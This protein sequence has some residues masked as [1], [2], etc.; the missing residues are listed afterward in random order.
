[1]S[2]GP[3]PSNRAWPGDP[4]TQCLTQRTQQGVGV[5]RVSRAGHCQVRVAPDPLPLGTRGG[6]LTEGRGFGALP[7]GTP[8]QGTHGFHLEDGFIRV[9]LEGLRETLKWRPCLNCSYSLVLQGWGEAT[10]SGD[11]Y[12]WNPQVGVRGS[13]ALPPGAGRR[14]QVAH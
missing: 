1:M 9:A 6:S 8:V 14:S 4:R 5:T 11:P 7:L 2:W 10:S 3:S 12:C 13:P